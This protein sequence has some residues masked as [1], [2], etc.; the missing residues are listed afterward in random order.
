MRGGSLLPYESCV[1]GS[2]N[3][4]RMVRA[5]DEGPEVDWERLRHAVHLG[6]RFLDDVVEV[7]RAPLP[8]IE[9]AT[10]GNRKIGLGV[11]GF[12]E[13]LILLGVPYDSDEAV[14]W[15]D[16]LAGF[17]AAEARRASRELAE[18]RG[19]FPDWARS[20]YAA[21]G[22]RVRNASRLSVAPTGTISIIA[23]TTGGIEPLFALAYRREHTLGGAPLVE[24]NT[25]FRRHLEA[26]RPDADRLLEEIV[27]RG[28]L[29]GVRG[30]PERLRRLFVTATEV[31]PHQ[32]LR[33]QHAF[34]RPVDNAVSKTIALPEECAPDEVA[35]VY[36]K[37]WRLGL[38]GIT[39]YRYG[40]KD[41]QVLTL[42]AGEEMAAREYFAKCDPGACR[43]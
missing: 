29:R 10:R 42:G 25:V 26:Q 1:L 16:R 15:A 28:R 35:H 12:A 9:E 8:E 7:T 14:A 17:I 21:T 36:L 37:A 3:L 5:G 27:A 33:I 30:I 23:G 4:A 43:L 32:H 24:V 2:V 38:K 20:V 41:R 34:Q 22:E 13:F 31:A 39:V 6:V 11:M 40:S 19:V 18:S